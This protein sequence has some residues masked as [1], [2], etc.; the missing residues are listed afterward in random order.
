MKSTER[1]QAIKWLFEQAVDLDPEQRA[2]F[3]ERACPDDSGLRRK[4]DKLLAAADR[5]GGGQLS[6]LFEPG[7]EEQYSTRSR[8]EHS[9]PATGRSSSSDDADTPRVGDRIEHYELIRM[10]GRGGMGL[11]YVARDIRLGRRVAI[12]F[13]AYRDESLAARFLTEARATAQCKHDNIVAIFDIGESQGY[14][15]MVLEY[16]EGITLREWLTER[17]RGQESDTSATTRRSEPVSMVQAVELVVPVVR[18]LEYAHARGM[19]HRDLKPENIMLGNDGAIKVL[20][21]GVAKVLEQPALS[22]GSQGELH[23]IQVERDFATRTGSLVGTP[24]YMSPEQWNGEDIDA[25]S[26][27]WAMGIILWEV[28]TGDHP[29]APLSTLRLMDVD[30]LTRSMPAISERRRDI[31]RLADIIDSCLCKRKAGRI[32]SAVALLEELEP[33]L[34]EGRRTGLASGNAGDEEANP[35]AGVAAFQEA[36]AARFF[37]RER[38]SVS[39]MTRLRHHRMIA[40]VGPSGA[41]KSSFIRAG[42]IPALKRSGPRWEAFIV[43]PGREPLLALAN[44]LLEIASNHSGEPGAADPGQSDADRQTAHVATLRRQPGYLGA[45]LR[46]RSGQRQARILLFVDQFEELYTLGAD[47]QTRTAFVGAL[48]GVADDVSSPLRVVLSLRSDFLDRVTEDRGFS[49]ELSEG[50]WL[51]PPM[52]RDEQRQA[53]TLPLEATGYRFESDDMIEAAL[54][55]LELTRSPLPLLQFTAA[56]LWDARDRKRRLI[57]E[58]S[59]SELG[60]VAG[61]L[62]AHADAVLTGFSAPDRRLA[63]LIVTNLVTEER[64]R[65]VVSA[66]ELRA[67]APDRMGDALEHVIQNL[68]RA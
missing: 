29:L 11:V 14:S 4:L 38:D 67:L 68:A 44:V 60:G 36:D 2:G 26:D 42:V 39:L 5:S 46:R 64:T 33:L 58:D 28:L 43:R 35:Y 51:L 10:L 18:A 8:R 65:A 20:D 30:D 53:L 22:S 52:G 40:V 41:G 54:D 21:L 61:T 34:R 24:P 17:H 3:L 37:G 47:R 55:A 7:R 15:Y 66:S 48:E 49:S 12:K 16:I 32:P 50:L 63:R 19:V 57:T 56:H 23:G 62:A 1:N 13:M 31:G 25:R 6:E 27:L 9:A 59:Y 45:A